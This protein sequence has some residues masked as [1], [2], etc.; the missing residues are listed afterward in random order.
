MVGPP[1]ARDW[2]AQPP[3]EIWKQPGGGGFAAFVISGNVAVTI[4]QIRGAEAV[5][6]YDIATGKERWA[7]DYAARFS[8]FQGGPGPRATPTIAAGKVYSVGAKGKL[9]CIDLATGKLDWATDILTDND[10]IQWGMSGSPLVYD[11]VVVVNPGG[12]TGPSPCKTDPSFCTHARSQPNG[13]AS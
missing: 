11:D 8:D 4:E 3:R 6:C 9:T 5:V 2:E 1:L 10:N 13:Q 7:R 12:P